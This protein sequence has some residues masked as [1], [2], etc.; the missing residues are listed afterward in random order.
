[1][2]REEVKNLFKHKIPFYSLREEYINR[3]GFN[4][5]SRLSIVYKTNTIKHPLELGISNFKD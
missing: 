2:Q 3:N 4:T 5:N 1:M